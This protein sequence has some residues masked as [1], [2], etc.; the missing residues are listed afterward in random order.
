MDEKEVDLRDYIKLIFGNKKLIFGLFLLGIIIAA[1]F[2][3]AFI[4]KNKVYE[5]KI[6]LEIGYKNK[7]ELVE[8]LEQLLEKIEQGVYG[9]YADG[10]I[11]ASNPIKTN[12]IEIK[13]EGSDSGEIKS[14]L[15]E[16]SGAI[17]NAHNKKINAKKEILESETNKIQIKI[18][19]LGQEEKNIELEMKTSSQQ[20][21][22]FLLKNDL[23]AEGQQLNKFKEEMTDIQPTEIISFSTVA[24]KS[25]NR[26]SL[27]N[28]VI[29][30]I[31]GLFTGIF[32]AFL[33][34]WWRKSY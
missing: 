24:E 27:L 25:L 32:L 8:Q 4:S 7:L 2:N 6:L 14:A 13:I 28:V 21:I 5:G 30:G 18:D 10:K 11:I 15:D 29:G 3:Y 19:L 16:V 23:R 31:S 26:K 33:L 22:L 1:G 12:L 34:A 9:I 17:L 20:L